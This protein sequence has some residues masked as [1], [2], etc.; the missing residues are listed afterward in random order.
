MNQKLLPIVLLAVVTLTLVGIVV[1]IVYAVRSTGQLVRDAYASD[2]TSEFLI[3]HLQANNDQ[4]PRGWGDLKDEYD[5]LAAPDHYPFTF[6][7]LQDRV[8]LDWN[9]DPSELPAADPPQVVFRLRSGRKASYGG[10]PNVRIRDYLASGSL[11]NGA[12]EP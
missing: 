11:K 12:R 2:W 5:T 3:A 7:E 8:E 9:V 4:W 10:D 1:G 6:A